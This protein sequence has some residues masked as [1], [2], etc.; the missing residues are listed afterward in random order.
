MWNP[1][2]WLHKLQQLTQLK[3]TGVSET[4]QE[5]WL[6][7]SVWVGCHQVLPHSERLNKFH[8][9]QTN[10]RTDRHKDIAITWSPYTSKQELNNID[11][12][13]RK[14]YMYMILRLWC[15]RSQNNINNTR[16]VASSLWHSHQ[17]S[18]ISTRI[19]RQRCCCQVNNNG[20][21]VGCTA[22]TKCAA[23]QLQERQ[24]ELRV[25]WQW[26]FNGSLGYPTH[27]QPQS[28]NA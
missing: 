16:T 19:A 17:H 7:G 18:H 4:I 24:W 14:T 13:Y 20:T 26:A 6:C 5:L 21:A 12:L 3:L 27:T 8:M 2:N 15:H 1:Y 9:R 25:G 10:E 28:H 11:L 23:P 22:L